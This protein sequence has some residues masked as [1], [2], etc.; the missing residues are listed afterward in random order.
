MSR[1]ILSS[2]IPND[3]FLKRKFFREKTVIN[4]TSLVYIS[5][6]EAE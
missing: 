6:L 2:R 4:E 1:L 3:F 5:S